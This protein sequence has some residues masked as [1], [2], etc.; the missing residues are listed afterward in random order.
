MKLSKAKAIM[1]STSMRIDAKGSSRG[2]S[3]LETPKIPS[4]LKIF[5]PIKLP[6]SMSVCRLKTAMSEL[7]SSGRLV[8][9]AMRV[10]PITLSGTPKAR[11]SV[12]A[13]ST[14]ACAPKTS[15]TRPAIIPKMLRL[16][17]IAST[18]SSWASL[19]LRS[20]QMIKPISRLSRM[21]PSKR[22]RLPLAKKAR[23]IKLAK[24]MMGASLLKMLLVLTAMGNN[25]THKPN[26]RPRFAM[27]EPMTLP[28]A[29]AGESLKVAASVAANSGALV[30]KATTVKPITRGLKLKRNAKLEANL[31]SSSPPT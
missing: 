27:F 19:G 13:P 23:A 20:I 14:S 9:T 26:I 11:A 29:I 7:A 16:G 6:N 21:P 8:P 18:L 12:L 25:K 24:S 10:K 31:T 1:T 2:K 5:E 28:T 4:M 15:N 3:K 30:P 22:L 17:F